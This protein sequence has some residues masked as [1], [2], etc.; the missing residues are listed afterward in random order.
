MNL[1]QFY[2][3]MNLY[4]TGG[5]AGNSG[6]YG[7]Y[8]LG[9]TSYL[10]G[11]TSSNQSS[12]RQIMDGVV[13]TS[14]GMVTPMDDIFEEAAKATGVDVRL[15]KAVG[16]A[17]SGFDA[18]ATSSCGAM[19]VM[20]LMPSTA[21]SLGV[22]NAYDARENIMGGARYLASLL[23]QYDGDTTLALAAYNAGSGNVAKYGGVPPFKE[24]QTYITRV[25]EY[26]GQDISTGQYV[27]PWTSLYY[28]GT[29]GLNGMT[30]LSG[31]SA[32][33]A[34]NTMDLD[35]GQV[36]K[37]MMEQMKLEL[38]QKTSLAFSLTDE[39]DEDEEKRNGFL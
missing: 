16:K 37:M 35:Y 8:G 2:T 24:T 23:R 32:L 33:S 31:S 25:L 21:A 29:S 18:S 9:N 28:G 34:L 10:T 36:F 13:Q 27:N 7:N 17:E 12:F 14:G 20:Q 1:S 6:V 15:L 3:F 38:E 22:Q 5:S 4:Q 26:A 19:G 39:D 30:G 11:T